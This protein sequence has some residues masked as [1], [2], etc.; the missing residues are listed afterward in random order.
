MTYYQNKIL[1]KKCKIS[2]EIYFDNRSL[3]KIEI[4]R[5]LEPSLMV[6]TNL[7]W[8]HCRERSLDFYSTL[9]NVFGSFRVKWSKS[10]HLKQDNGQQMK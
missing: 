8:Q 5:E 9:E 3:I 6:K 1:E 7:K 10:I 4:K 2:L